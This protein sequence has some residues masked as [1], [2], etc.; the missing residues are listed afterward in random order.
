MTHMRD[1]STVEL[2]GRFVA[3]IKP[4]IPLISV[5]A[6]GSLAAGDY[7]PTRSDLDLIAVVSRHITDAEQ[8]RLQHVHRHLI[9]DTALA[10]KLH[11]SYI[12]IHEI[13]DSGIKHL[14]WAHQELMH[15]PVTPVTRREL[16]DGGS[17]LYGTAPAD[18][19]PPLTDR[20]LVDF[21]R[22]DLGEYWRPAARHRRRW[23]RDIWVDL[24]LLT[25]ARATV[26]LRDGRLI[27]KR[28]ALDVLVEMGA[29]PR[30]V[31]DIRERRYGDPHPISPLWRIRRARLARNFLRMAIDR[32]LAAS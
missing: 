6:H 28:Q 26:T 22:Q 14:T 27:T 8:Q 3:D 5:W 4:V 16:L 7:Q 25:L 20:E 24:G 1:S 29:P 9:H 32:T 21:I 23:L 17:V 12:V 10:G 30:V 18:T 2:L 11:C 15:R 19:M 31:D 13:S